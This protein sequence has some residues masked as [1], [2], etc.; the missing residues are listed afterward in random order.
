MAYSRMVEI[1]DSIDVVWPM[2]DKHLVFQSANC[3]STWSMICENWARET[4]PCI[5]KPPK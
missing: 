2:S 4:L 5:I 1:V 3:F